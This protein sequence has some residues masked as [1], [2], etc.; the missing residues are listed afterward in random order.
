MQSVNLNDGSLS[1]IQTFTCNFASYSVK[2][3]W[4]ANVIVSFGISSQTYFKSL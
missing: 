4:S 1:V 2:L 3:L